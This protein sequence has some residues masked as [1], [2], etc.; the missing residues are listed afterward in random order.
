MFSLENALMFL[1]Y[2]EAQVNGLPVFVAEDG[3]PREVQ[4]TNNVIWHSLKQTPKTWAL[5][6]DK[7]MKCILNRI[8][9]LNDGNIKGV[10]VRVTSKRL[11]SIYSGL[12]K[13]L[14]GV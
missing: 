9:D 5:S 2:Y 4:I 12:Q 13:S 7:K 1:V 10:D 3:I 14:Q 11:E 6:I 8:I